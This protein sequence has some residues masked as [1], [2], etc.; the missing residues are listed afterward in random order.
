MKRIAAG[1]LVALLT[2]FAVGPIVA[3]VSRGVADPRVLLEEL[4]SPGAQAAIR[5]TL[6]TSSGATLIAVLLGVPM[7]FLLERTD[8]PARKVFAMAFTSLIALPPF[9][10][11]M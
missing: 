2:A 5:A 1:G 10:L 6:L 8:L 11:G 4:V 3:L 7:A 9:V